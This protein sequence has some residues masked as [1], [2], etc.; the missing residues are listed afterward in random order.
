MIT[1]LGAV[2]E[3]VR[4]ELA[5]EAAAQDKCI[6]LEQPNAPVLVRGDPNVIEIA[7]RN[8]AENAIRHS[9]PG[10]TIGLRIGA[11]AHLE[12][13]DAGPGI[14]DELRDMIFE[15]FWSGD[16]HVVSA[17]LGL[18]IV[19]RVAERYDVR[20][21]VTAAPGGGARFALHFQPA[22]VHLSDLD[23]ATARA[24]IPASLAHRRRPETLDRA[25]G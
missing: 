6:E 11:D 15:P 21:T 7:V 10:S 20:V 2:G 13:V 17:G 4:D 1:D 18:T 23:P 25:A 16:P 9:P 5:T 22:L 12:V 3:A 24:S 8:L 19:R 14:A